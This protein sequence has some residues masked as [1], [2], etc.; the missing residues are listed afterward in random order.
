MAFTSYP[1]MAYWDRLVTKR[2]TTSE[3]IF[4]ICRAV[5]IPSI[6]GMEISSRMI[7]NWLLN[8]RRKTAPF[9][10]SCENSCPYCCRYFCKVSA[11]ACSSSTIAMRMISPHYSDFPGYSTSFFQY[12]GIYGELQ[13]QKWKK[14]SGR[15]LPAGRSAADGGMVFSRKENTLLSENQ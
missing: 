15:S 1:R 7:S 2:S 11:Q 12:T 5:S 13:S 6:T 10:S 3:S 14:P 8:S 9:S 4:R